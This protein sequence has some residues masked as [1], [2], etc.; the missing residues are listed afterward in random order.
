M[1]FH[2]QRWH[3][4]R[5]DRP[6]LRSG[7]IA[8]V[9]SLPERMKVTLAVYDVQGKRVRT[10]VDAMLEEGRQERVWDGKDSR[11]RPAASGVYFYRLETADQKL[12]R[13]MLLLK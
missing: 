13:K 1:K 11:G 6:E 3:Q 7:P 4:L 8:R 9:T 12:T 5:Y 10:L 2:C